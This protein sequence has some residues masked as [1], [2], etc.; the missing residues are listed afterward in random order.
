MHPVPLRTII[1]TF[2]ALVLCFA[3]APERTQAQI[4]QPDVRENIGGTYAVDGLNPDGTRYG[5]IARIRVVGDDVTVSWLVGSTAYEGAGTYTGD[6]RLRIEWP[7]KTTIIF[8]VGND[9]TLSGT[10]AN[11][12][13][14]ERLLPVK[15]TAR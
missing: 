13:A 7:D 2:F 15:G 4:F 1:T 5:G 6:R 3:F 11:G 9:G 8:T 14:R 10:W 12:Q